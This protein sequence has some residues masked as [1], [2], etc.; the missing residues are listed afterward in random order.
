MHHWTTGVHILTGYFDVLANR[1]A[2]FTLSSSLLLSKLVSITDYSEHEKVLI[3]L[4]P[5]HMNTHPLS[6]SS[7]GASTQIFSPFVYLEELQTF[8]QFICFVFFPIACKVKNM[9]SPNKQT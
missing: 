3:F 4:L 1:T 7:T 5:P 6:Q 8:Q 9:N 2:D